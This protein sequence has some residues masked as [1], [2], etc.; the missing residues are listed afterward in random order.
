MDVQRGGCCEFIEVVV[1][2]TFDVPFVAQGL[3]D[4]E[5]LPASEGGL[6]SDILYEFKRGIIRFHVSPRFAAVSAACTLDP[7][8][9]GCLK[10][11]FTEVPIFCRITDLRF[12]VS[13][14]FLSNERYV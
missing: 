13:N 5:W 8:L 12:R 4:F 14:R 1:V 7:P 6:G 3:K 2:V 9:G 11:D 10:P